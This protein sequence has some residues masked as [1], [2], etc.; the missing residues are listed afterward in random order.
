[1]NQQLAMSHIGM[2]QCVTQAYEK[3]LQQEAAEGSRSDAAIDAMSTR[4]L[5]KNLEQSEVIVD[6]IQRRRDFVAPPGEEPSTPTRGQAQAAANQNE[7]AGKDP[8]YFDIGWGSVTDEDGKT[9]K[10]VSFFEG[11]QIQGTWA[12][13]VNDDLTTKEKLDEILDDCIPC[14]GRGIPTDPDLWG[15][16][17]LDLLEADLAM[18]MN[19]L[20]EFKNYLNTIRPF[21]ELCNVLQF[22][23]FLCIPDLQM[24]L[25]LLEQALRQNLEGLAKI[26]LGNAIQDIVA[27]MVRPYIAGMAGLI[28]L[29]LRMIYRPID[30][31]LAALFA[32]AT[33]IP[34]ATAWV[35]ELQDI[36]DESFEHNRNVLDG[37]GPV[38]TRRISVDT[39]ASPKIP[40]G[41]GE[42]DISVQSDPS[43][44]I[45]NPGIVNV[46]HSSMELIAVVVMETVTGLRAALV[47]MEDEF[48]RVLGLEASSA[49]RALS[50]SSNLKEIARL[51]NI[52]RVII[53]LKKRYGK[54]PIKFC[55]GPLGE[56]EVEELVDRIFNPPG[57]SSLGGGPR[58][59][60]VTNGRGGIEGYNVQIPGV[61]KDE[62]PEVAFISMAKC[63]G[64][65]AS[66][67]LS[68]IHKWILD[69]EK[70]F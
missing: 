25:G 3:F 35:E 12:H 54:D 70:E 63:M 66:S 21:H 13:V 49:S 43:R 19:W 14:D 29:W 64:R 39:S 18:R 6:V 69:R 67:D 5:V 1:M 53:D 32:Q 65:A 55:A 15:K 47:T 9:H 45:H 20:A 58:A 60:V 40:R 7:A 33:K 28:D 61:Y 38:R 62:K 23:N 10:A 44:E 48:K 8:D 34:G 17:L 68:E 36:R 4:Q 52:I 27:A 2:A 30:C 51:V 50:F 59:D 24:L 41:A 57:E 11:Q 31:V 16:P 22:F 46:V 42:Y 56:D 37:S 26:S